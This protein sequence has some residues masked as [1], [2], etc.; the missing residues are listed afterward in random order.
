MHAEQEFGK[1]ALLQ[2]FPL[3][4]GERKGKE[5]FAKG[6][7]VYSHVCVSVC[8]R[9]GVSDHM[10]AFVAVIV[11]ADHCFPPVLA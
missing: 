2:Q 3:S 6:V 10:S 4:E 9:E 11:P 8:V 7:C 5:H 1:L